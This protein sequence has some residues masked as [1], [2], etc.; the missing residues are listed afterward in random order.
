MHNIFKRKSFYLHC[1]H[2]FKAL[3]EVNKDAQNESLK[4][5]AAVKSHL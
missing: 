3:K 2:L 5:V 1:F 4:W